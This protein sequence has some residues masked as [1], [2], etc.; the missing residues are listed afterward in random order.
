M[1]VLGS[2]DTTRNKTDKNLCIQG[3][4]N[5]VESEWTIKIKDVIVNGWRISW[6]IQCR[7]RIWSVRI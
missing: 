4:Y 1:T 2:V 5:L 6:E 7:V 3:V